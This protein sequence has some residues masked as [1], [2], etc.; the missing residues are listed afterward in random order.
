M[1]KKQKDEQANIHA[2]DIGVDPLID[3]IDRHLGHPGDDKDVDGH[4][5][6][7]DSDHGDDADDNAEPNWNSTFLE[8]PL[9]NIPPAMKKGP[10]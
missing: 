2:D 7:D 8:K 6:Q 5:R 10:I 9:I 4:G 3:R 1:G